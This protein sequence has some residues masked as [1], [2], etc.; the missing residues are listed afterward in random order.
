MPVYDDAAA[1]GGEHPGGIDGKGADLNAPLTLDW[2]PSPDAYDRILSRG[3]VPLEQAWH[4]GEAIA[5]V[6]RN[7]I[8]RAIVFRDGDPVG[9]LQVAE[10]ILPAGI[11][12]VRIVRGPVIPDAAAATPGEIARAIRAGFPRWSRTLL[13]WMPDLPPEDAGRTLT[14]IG[15]RPM[16]APYATAWLDL[17]ASPEELRKRLRGNWRNQLRKAEANPPDVWNRSRPADIDRFVAG[18]ASERRRL[19]YR[20]PDEAL[21]RCIF[22]RFGRQALLLQAVSSGTTIASALFLRHHGSATYY[23]S[24]TRPEG[25]EKSFSNYLIWQGILLLKKSGTGWLD[26]GGLNAAAPG[27]ASFKLGTGAQPKITSGTWF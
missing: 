19:R 2:S 27:V 22:D 26:L 12:L 15:K 4:Y 1:E 7:G 9:A 16:T 3:A 18:Y 25:R 21:A 17:S 10:R 8:R 14:P 13:F 5:A 24:W 20:G 6:S 23:L 11:R